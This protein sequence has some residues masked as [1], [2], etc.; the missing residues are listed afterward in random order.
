MRQLN[1][2]DQQFLAVENS[3]HN[4]HVG[5]LYLLEPPEGAPVTVGALRE[6]VAARVHLLEPLRRK[7]MEVPLRFDRPYWVEVD[8][9]DLDAHVQVHV[10]AR[11]G[12]ETELAAL[13]ADLHARALDRDRPLWALHLI[14]GL[15]EGRQAVFGKVHHAVVDGVSAAALLG[16]LLDRSAD[17]PAALPDTVAPRRELTPR[18]RHLVGRGLA[19]A[20]AHPARSLRSLPRLLP[21]LD[22]MPGADRVPGS[23]TVATLAG[24]VPGW[25]SARVAD[26]ERP[27]RHRLRVPPTPFNAPISARRAVAF[28]SVP[29]AQ[30]RALR[31]AFACSDNDVVLALCAGLLRAW[32]SAHQ[33]LPERPLVIGVP[34]SLRAPRAEDGSHRGGGNQVSMMTAPLP[35]HLADPV[36]RLEAIAAA[37]LLAKRQI[38]GMPENWLSDVTDLV[39][40]AL[41]G[42]TTRSIGRV[43]HGARR[44]P[45]NLVISNVPGPH[46]P[47]YLAGARMVAHYPVSAVSDV[48]GGLNITVVGHD[49]DLDFGFVA[50]PDLVPDIAVLAAGLPAALA[51]LQAAIPAGKAH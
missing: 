30:V 39:P 10:V 48:L 5:G 27:A 41:L 22:R 24:K 12:G 36:E 15:V 50:C 38:S 19:N 20:V 16:A 43:L 42:L 44:H 32:L 45:V 47:L 2:F 25:S 26:D 17:T 51:E 31:S 37:M 18:R 8:E 33:A 4:G 11:P 14:D 28:G 35:T 29:V 7:V 46:V 34:V 9:L 13:V 40:A 6:L 49:G 23:R 1:S 3:T 21:H